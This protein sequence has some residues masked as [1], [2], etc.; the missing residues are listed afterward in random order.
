MSYSK[1][2]LRFDRSGIGVGVACGLIVLGLSSPPAGRAAPFAVQSGSAGTIQSSVWNI[3]G[4]SATPVLDPNTGM[5]L[6]AGSG[7][8]LLASQSGPNNLTTGPIVPSLSAVVNSS[9]FGNSLFGNSRAFVTAVSTSTGVGGQGVQAG[10]FFTPVA[11]NDIVGGGTASVSVST[12][13][14]TFQ[15]NGAAVTGTLGD[16]LSV[17]GSVDGLSTDFIEAAITGTYSINGATPTKFNP[18]VVAF[19]GTSNSF[20]EELSASDYKTV[21]Q[22]LPI[23]NGSLSVSAAFS[24]FGPQVTIHTGDTLAFTATVTLIADPGSVQVTDVP[25]GF[26]LPDFG[27]F[28]TSPVPEP[29]SLIS[30]LVGMSAVGLGIGWRQ[31]AGRR[32]RPEG[33]D[34]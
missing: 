5:L 15:N 1:R 24:T 21:L 20:I 14:V 4:T 26:T 6:S 18:V 33:N 17:K 11:V 30:F 29:A 2:H 23:F 19:N 8:Q 32:R 3:N 31:S 9:N 25:A 34:V 7:Y 28:T 16:T 10:T 13:S 22:T 12:S 27:N